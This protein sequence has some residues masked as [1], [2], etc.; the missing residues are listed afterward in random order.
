MELKTI[1]SNS[2]C[3]HLNLAVESV[4][5]ETANCPVLYLWKNE[6]TV[7]I[8]ANQNP[9]SECA[10]E[11]LLG[12]G[13]TLARR[14]TGGGA[15]YHDLGNL[16]FSFIANKAQYDVC[17][18]LSVIQKALLLFGIKAEFSGRNDLTAEGK[19]FS[20]NAF[21][22]TG[23]NCLHH[24]TILIK[25]DGAKLSK[26]LTV[27]PAKLQKKGVA[28]VKSRVINLSELNPRLDSQNIIGELINS[29][30]KVYEAQSVPLTFDT[31]TTLPRAKI[32]F[33]KYASKEYLYGKWADFRADIVLNADWGLT[34]FAFRFEDN[35]IVSVKISS[36][37]LFPAVIE[38]AET[39]L[40]GYKPIE[41][42]VNLTQELSDA[43]KAILDEIFAFV[44]REYR[45][46]RV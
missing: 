45:V 37:C 38:L 11:S 31:L 29:F 7:V 2:Y 8:G 9:Y 46:C 19:K 44:N 40:M 26:Y 28:S 36:D 24:G 5:I 6:N 30:E 10:V 13:G 35:R 18:Q 4:L 1:V 22:K 27:N 12:D 32:L 25:T 39:L 3:P 15:V 16:N 17:K 21:F 33:E 34:E 20:G 23:A 14:R 41:P 43:E 42:L